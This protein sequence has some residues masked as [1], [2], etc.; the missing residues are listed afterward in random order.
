M[1]SRG[2]KIVALKFASFAYSLVFSTP[3]LN[4]CLIRTMKTT[5]NAISMS[6]LAVSWD[7]KKKI[8]HFLN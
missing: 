7:I 1:Y 5:S 2:L 6:S 3:V 8:E 4:Y